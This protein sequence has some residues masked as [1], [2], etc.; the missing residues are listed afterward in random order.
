[1]IRFRRLRRKETQ[2][3]R[4]NASARH[5]PLFPFHYPRCS[6]RCNTEGTL[7]RA[8]KTSARE[9][10]CSRKGKRAPNERRERHVYTFMYTYKVREGGAHSH[11]VQED[12]LG[13]CPTERKQ[14]HVASVCKTPNCR[15][16]ELELEFCLARN[17][18]R[19]SGFP[20]DCR[21][22]FFRGHTWCNSE[23]IFIK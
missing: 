10:R 9:M 6:L 2:C 14:D 4:G 17:R 22:F 18:H 23:K 13:L 21:V 8:K 11:I 12:Y 15:F 5:F 1:M 16:S 3:E 19:C 20:K 7:P